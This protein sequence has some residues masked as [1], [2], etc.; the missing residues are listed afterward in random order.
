MSYGK[1]TNIIELVRYFAKTYRYGVL[2]RMALAMGPESV[3]AAL[4]DMLRLVDSLYARKIRVKIVTEDNKE[5]SS[6][7][8]C[9]YGED[10]GY[11]IKGVVK[12]VHEP[13]ELE[14]SYKDKRIYCAPC[15]PIPYESEIRDFLSDVEKDPSIARKVVLLSCGYK[16]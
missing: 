11:G 16:G 15:P 8:C 14:S 7:S 6:I 5:Y 2:D 12:E 4:Y 13:K 3:E 10:L 9:E 1:Y